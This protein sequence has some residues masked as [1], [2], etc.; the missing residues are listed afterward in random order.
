[1]AR[2]FMAVV[3]F[4]GVEPTSK[5][6][7]DAANA[8]RALLESA[9]WVAVKDNDGKTEIRVLAA[10]EEPKAEQ[11]V[12]DYHDRYQEVADTYWKHEKE[13]A[14][15]ISQLNRQFLDRQEPVTVDHVNQY[16]RDRRKLKE[17]LA[18][19]SP[20]RAVPRPPYRHVLRQ[21][22]WWELRLG[23]KPVE[24]V[25]VSTILFGTDTPS[26]YL[27]LSNASSGFCTGLPGALQHFP[28]PPDDSYLRNTRIE[29]K[30]QVIFLKTRQFQSY[31]LGQFD[32][33]EAVASLEEAVP[34]ATIDGDP[35]SSTI[36][37]LGFP[38]EHKAIRQAMAQLGVNREKPKSQNETNGKER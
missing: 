33:A 37:V 17:Q 10:E 36:F 5:T 4:L 1:M 6:T 13:Y 23:V 15:A 19:K 12:R 21:G 9:S 31:R 32:I 29:V 7:D 24:P 8:A 30:E 28:V 18:A 3:L 25:S 35:E 11:A 34:N 14:D 26:I 22:E 38:D 16:F 27:R 2:F 20:Q